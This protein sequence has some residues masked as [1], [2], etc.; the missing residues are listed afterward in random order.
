MFK[1]I[2]NV[3]IGDYNLEQLIIGYMTAILFA[4]T[5]DK[6][7]HFDSLGLSIL[8]FTKET[9]ASIEKDCSL[10]R[11]LAGDERLKGGGYEQAG[12]DFLFTR[13]GHG[14]GFY[15]RP[16]V[17]GDV[18]SVKLESIAESFGSVSYYIGDDNKIHKM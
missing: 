10:F 11:E 1:G 18:N 9:I 2:E 3:N 15:T 17:W 4:E 8:S 7:E 5:D 6:G 12:I 14:E 16:E 13:R